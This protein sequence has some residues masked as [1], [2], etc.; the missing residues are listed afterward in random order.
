VTDQATGFL[1]AGRRSRKV[2]HATA[3]VVLIETGSGSESD[4]ED[5][6]DRSGYIRRGLTDRVRKDQQIRLCGGTASVKGV[7]IVP[8]EGGCHLG[9]SRSVTRWGQ[10]SQSWW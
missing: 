10:P 2:R 4:L 8:E 9:E 1:S 7:W 6:L 5:A 3:G